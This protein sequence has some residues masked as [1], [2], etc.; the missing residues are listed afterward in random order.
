MFY[1][2]SIAYYFY[3]DDDIFTEILDKKFD[4]FEQAEDALEVK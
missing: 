3:D 2:V 4:T 1:I